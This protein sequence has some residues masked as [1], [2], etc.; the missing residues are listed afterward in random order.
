MKKILSISF[1]I[2]TVNLIVIYLLPKKIFLSAGKDPIH[3]ALMTPLSGSEKTNGKEILNATRLYIDQ[4]NAEGGIDGRKINLQTYDDKSDKRTAMELA[5]QLSSENKALLILGHYYSTISAEAGKIYKKTGIPAITGFSVLDSVTSGNEWYFRTIPNVTFQTTF[6]ANYISKVFKKKSASIIFVKDALGQAKAEVFEKVTRNLGIEIKNK[7]EFD[8]EGKIS[9]DQQLMRIS[10]EIRASDD[11]GVLFLALY[12]AEGAKIIRSIKY[13]D[14]DYIIIGSDGYSDA[15]F[16][17][18]LRKYPREQS[19]PGYYSDGIY[20]TT[21]FLTDIAN[22]KARAFT[23]AFSEKYGR[24]PS[25]WIGPS[26]YDAAHVAVE[27]IKRAGIEGTRIRNDRMK[28]KEAMADFYSYDNAVEGVSGHL[29]FDKNGDVQ[30]TSSMGFYENQLFRPSFWQYQPI[31]SEGIDDQMEKSLSGELMDIEGSTVKRTPVVFAG[32]SINEIR[33]LDMKNASYTADFYLWFR[34]P[35]KFDDTHVTF[36]NSVESIQIGGQ[37]VAE[38]TKNDVTTKIYHII[39]RFKNDFDFREYPFDRHELTIRLRHAAQTRDKLFFVADRSGMPDLGKEGVGHTRLDAASGWTVR[40]TSLYQDIVKDISVSGKLDSSDSQK[41]L[42]Y[43]Q[44]N[45]A[46]RIERSDPGFILK[47]FLPIIAMIVILYV[48]HFIPSDQ[49]L[50]RMIVSAVILFA[51]TDFHVRFLL[52][53][54][55][56]YVTLIG[57]AFFSV[58]IFVT[59]FVLTSVSAYIL[60]RKGKLGIL[61]ILDWSARIIYPFAVAGAGIMIMRI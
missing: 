22:E 26:A 44:V 24:E 41:L 60:H 11:P 6:I 31:S 10:E 46:V 47:S 48:T 39:A 35:G 49:V 58:Y 1:L 54:P 29:W 50:A 17:E 19:S 30:K 9:A 13:P 38:T 25:S 23:Q 59:I 2:L 51:N 3:I 12:S 16:L 52:Y 28:V 56:E 20:S 4:T 43:S 33:N 21:P 57:Y 5:Y 37:A 14:S 53:L 55:T 42:A 8:P 40:N 45:A 7:W 15:S 32:M 36:V 27:A 18:A 61:R 34:C